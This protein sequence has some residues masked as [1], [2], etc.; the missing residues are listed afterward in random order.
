M[1][2][3]TNISGIGE[4]GPGY[5]PTE[6][7][8][9]ALKLVDKHYTEARKYRK[10]YDAN[11]HEYYQQYRGK[12]WKEKRPSYRNSEVLNFI[13]AEI[14]TSIPILTD[15][16]PD[17]EY[18]PEDP[19]DFQF[20]EIIT[21]VV[22]SK[23][24]RDLYAKILT[25]GIK[26][27]LLYGTSI[28]YVPWKQSMAYGL[29]DF[30]FVTIDPGYFYPDP[31]IRDNI[32]DDYCE[33]VVHVEPMSVGKVKLMWP[34]KAK[35]VTADSNSVIESSAANRN[36][37]DNLTLKSPI[38]SR[39]LVSDGSSYI[40][41]TTNQVLVITDWMK[42]DEIVEERL[43]EVDPDSGE[44]REAFQTKL[45]YPTGRRIIIANG[46]LLEDGPNPYEDGKFP[47]AALIDHNLP[48]EFWGI[49]EIEN[50]K[51]PQQIINKVFSYML[52]VLTIMGN[53]IW[54][55]DT[56]AGIDTDTLTNRPG[57]IVEKNPGSEVRREAGVQL[58]PFIMELF[59][60]LYGNVIS[61]LG[62]NSEVSNGIAPSANTSGFQIQLLQ[63]A[64]QT[65]LRAKSRNIEYFLRDVGDLFLCRILQF[66]DQPRIIRLTNDQQGAQYFKFH[67]EKRPDPAN[68]NS[69][70][71]YG[72]VRELAAGPDGQVIEGNPQEYAI[73]GRLDVKITTG[74]TLPFAKAERQKRAQELYQLGIIDAEEYL[75]QIE[76]PNKEKIIEKL[77]QRQAAAAQAPPSPDGKLPPIPGQTP[78]APA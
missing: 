53:P 37:D 41:D 68:P 28:S 5:N 61:K 22:S 8:A 35:Y 74:T 55:V 31:N 44:I 18:I 36:I 29:G 2:D 15:T 23:W 46:V 45:K 24:D 3:L 73:K 65:K 71:S 1:G 16:R 32:N 11:F 59:Q 54:I 78:P 17:I 47:F 75:D 72:V 57:G 62:A 64:A 7:E 56:N 67:V 21:K 49:G 58:Q 13:F 60:T 12:Q 66:Y 25:D 76:Y 63:E 19:S 14:E 52:D 69:T 6:E 51:S 43:E 30:D 33:F 38:D 50:L 40:R 9:K 34:D 26:D 10:R 42:S 70:V 27:S 77:K 20:A 4:A 39:V 48:R